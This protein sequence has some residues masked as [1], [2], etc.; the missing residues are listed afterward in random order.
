[1]LAVDGFEDP[2]RYRDTARDEQMI[3]TFFPVNSVPFRIAFFN[4]RIIPMEYHPPSTTDVKGMVSGTYRAGFMPVTR[5]A[6]P[7]VHRLLHFVTAIVIVTSCILRIAARSFP[8]KLHHPRP[9][10]G[11]GT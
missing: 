5:N 10:R 4:V 1:M 11:I 3:T 8:G 2:S 9:R 7:H 6:Q